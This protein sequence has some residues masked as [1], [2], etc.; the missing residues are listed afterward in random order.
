MAGKEGRLSR[1]GYKPIYNVDAGEF[2]LY[3]LHAD[4][5]EQQ[6]LAGTAYRSWR[7]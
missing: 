4:P 2:E 7:P 5:D 6:D 1:D 3:D